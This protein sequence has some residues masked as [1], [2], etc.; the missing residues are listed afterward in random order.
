MIWRWDK[1]KNSAKE[2]GQH[3]GTVPQQLLGVKSRNQRARLLLPI[4]AENGGGRDDG[5]VGYKTRWQ[6]RKQPQHSKTN[7][8]TSKGIILKHIPAIGV[9]A[10]ASR[11]NSRA[12]IV[13]EV[14]PFSREG[15][16]IGY[17]TC[18]QA[19]DMFAAST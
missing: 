2:V 15:N 3:G 5:K 10:P 19:N 1:E 9:A 4:R 6:T 17:D 16:T 11:K 14:G 18:L 13:G 7:A 8:V 12:I